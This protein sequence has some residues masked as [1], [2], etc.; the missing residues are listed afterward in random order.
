MIHV[1]DCF[2][3]RLAVTNECPATRHQNILSA[4]FIISAPSQE[5]SSGGSQKLKVF[6]PEKIGRIDHI[7][8]Y[9]VKSCAGV[10]LESARMTK[11]GIQTISSESVRDREY[12]IVDANREMSTG[13]HKSLT[14][15]DR[16]LQKMALIVPRLRGDGIELSWDNQDWIDVPNYA[17][18]EL[19][20][21]VHKNFV[22]GVDQGDKV[23]KMIGNYLGRPVRLVRAS[24]SFT[25]T[26]NQNYLEND[27]TLNYQ[28]AYPI[29]WLFD[30]SVSRLSEILGRFVS[31]GDF[32]ANII[33]AGGVANSEHSFYRVRFGKVEGVQPKPGTRCMMV[34]VDQNSG[35]MQKGRPLPLQAIQL[36]FEWIDKYQQ[37]LPIFAE[38]FLP[39]VEGI[40]EKNDD[41]FALSPREPPL[42]YGARV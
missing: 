41:I 11:R 10:E 35:V 18:K 25:R 32:R 6:E 8:L 36:N 12:A 15:K 1:R 29:N 31:P 2:H 4:N 19:P 37:R 33:G 24:G 26:A 14:Q 28:D 9:P 23:A 13:Y 38:N 20:V 34:N 21:R 7:F 16:D 22:T 17:G 27:N 30:E 42:V 40:I 3:I 39:S 5:P